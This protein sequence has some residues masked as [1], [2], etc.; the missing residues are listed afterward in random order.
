MPTSG[1]QR[2]RRF[3]V[4]T[5][6]GMIGDVGFVVVVVV[7]VVTVRRSGV[8][9]I[10][11]IV[12]SCRRGFGDSLAL[13]GLYGEGVCCHLPSCAPSCLPGEGGL[14]G[15]ALALALVPLACACW[16]ACMS[17]RFRGFRGFRKSRRS[18]IPI[19]VCRT[20]KYALCLVSRMSGC[21][22]SGAG[23]R[24]LDRLWNVQCPMSNVLCQ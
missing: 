13:G 12:G 14:Y 5:R 11:G 6:K 2:G 7:A 15:V 4:D 21:R 8:G 23:C 22:S 10:V 16:F 18:R 17:R 3:N 24:S 9:S 20:P 1:V 19:N